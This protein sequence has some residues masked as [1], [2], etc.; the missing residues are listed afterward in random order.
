MAGHHTRSSRC[1]GT[2]WGSAP[3]QNRKQ[4]EPWASAQRRF[5]PF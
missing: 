5:W 1:S 3:G 4:P 2:S